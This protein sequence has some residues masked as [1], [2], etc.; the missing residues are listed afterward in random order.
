MVFYCTVLSIDLFNKPYWFLNRW[1]NRLKCLPN[2]K[3]G[4]ASTEG[5]DM[6]SEKDAQTQWEDPSLSDHNYS[7]G[8]HV[9][10]T[11]CEAGTQCPAA[12]LYKT[13]LRNKALCWL[14]TG[15]FLAAFSTLAEHLLSL[16]QRKLSVRPE[17]LPPDD[18][19]EAESQLAAAVPSRKVWCFQEYCQSSD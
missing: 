6:P 10:P 16:L 19:E 18:T 7:S 3:W 12:P 5:M 2:W 11:T 1:H 4:L 15:L 13:L 17:R 8:D 9:K 14:H